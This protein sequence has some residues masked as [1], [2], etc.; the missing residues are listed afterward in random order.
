MVVFSVFSIVGGGLIPRCRTNRAGS[1][2]RSS[3]VSYLH[4]RWA[5]CCGRAR[6][7]TRS[8][9]Q[10]ERVCVW[11]KVTPTPPGTPRRVRPAGYAPELSLLT[12][13]YIGCPPGRSQRI[14]AQSGSNTRP[15]LH[16][17]RSCGTRGL[18]SGCAHVTRYF[19]LP[20]PSWI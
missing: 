5:C 2:N 16:H 13:I 3:C 12:R 17:P 10:S 18:N 15:T 19:V 20:P 6:C 11:N 1:P 8:G 4:P 9:L 14:L 7:P